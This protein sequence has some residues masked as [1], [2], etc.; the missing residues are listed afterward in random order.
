MIRI[1]FNI[2]EGCATQHDVLPK[3]DRPTELVFRL[4]ALH[5]QVGDEVVFSTRFAHAKKVLIAGDFNNWQ[6][7]ATPTMSNGKPGDFLARL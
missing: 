3:C 5:N 6:P 4:A 1:A 7:T 2:V